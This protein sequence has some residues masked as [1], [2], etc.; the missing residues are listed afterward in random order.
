M[1]TMA[2]TMMRFVEGY[3]DGENITHLS[4]VSP[5][6][7]QQLSVKKKKWQRSIINNAL[8]LKSAL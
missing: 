8:T 7:L 6:S 3:D 2:M 1:T 5:V 4:V